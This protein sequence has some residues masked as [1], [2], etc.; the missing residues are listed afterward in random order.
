LELRVRARRT[1]ATQVYGRLCIVDANFR[2][3]LFIKPFFWSRRM[4]A[5]WPRAF[6]QSAAV[7]QLLC[8]KLLGPI[9]FC[10]VN[11]RRWMSEPVRHWPALEMELRLTEL[12][13]QFDYLLNTLR[14]PAN[15]RRASSGGDD[16]RSSAVVEVRIPT[17]P[18]RRP[19]Y[20]RGST[21][22]LKSE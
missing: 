15:M 8:F 17:A 9:R 13:D 14:R 4:R 16:R 6:T 18:G 21:R 7:F 3:P 19:A 12:R 22:C 10:V 1:R 2:H 5:A 11:P 20:Q